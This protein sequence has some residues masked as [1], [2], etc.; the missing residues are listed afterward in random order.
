[1]REIKIKNSE[2]K[3]QKGFDLISPLSSEK[4]GGDSSPLFYSQRKNL[5]EAVID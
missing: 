1:M 3:F 4:P 5:W 2:L